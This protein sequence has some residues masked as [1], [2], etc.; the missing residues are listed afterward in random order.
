MKGFNCMRRMHMHP[1]SILKLLQADREGR[2]MDFANAYEASDRNKAA[3]SEV[4]QYTTN[5]VEIS[6]ETLKELS[7]QRAT[8]NGFFFTLKTLIKV[9][10]VIMVVPFLMENK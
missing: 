2:H 7:V 3:L 1:T 9:S 5:K 10:P 6:E 4:E 8:T